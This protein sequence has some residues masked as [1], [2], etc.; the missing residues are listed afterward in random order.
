LSYQ[1]TKTWR[2]R[3]P[4]TWQRQKARYYE[5]N[6]NRKN[7]SRRSRQEWSAEEIDLI[8]MKPER[9]VDQELSEKMGRSVQAIQLKRSVL[10]KAL[11]KGGVM[12][13]KK[14]QRQIFDCLRELDGTAT[15]RE[16]AAKARLNVN[17]VSQSL[18]AMYELVECLGGHGGDTRWRIK[19]QSR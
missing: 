18:G 10:R 14:R 2:K 19:T 15:T 3:H 8:M 9:R 12:A 5:N 17:G 16:I 4:K 13:L 11:T 6:R 1:A 7:C